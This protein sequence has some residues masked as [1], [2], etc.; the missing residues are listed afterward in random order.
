MKKTLVIAEKH[1]AALPMAK[2]LNCIIEKDGYM[3]GDEYII[4]WADGHL[5]GYQYPEEYNADY[6]EWKLEDLPLKFEPD[7]CLKVL[8]GKEKQFE[9]IKRLIQGE[10]TDKIINAGDAGRE[11]YLIQ[12]WI[13]KLAGNKKPVK[14]LW[15]S[16]L[17]EDALR[18]AFANLRDDSEFE[19][20]RKE[21]EARSEMDYILGMNYSRLLTLKCSNDITL[22]YGRCMT[23]LLNLIVERENEISEFE[24]RK[25]YSVE[26]EFEDGFKAVLIDTE[27]KEVVFERASD[28][29]GVI[30][31]IIQTEGALT[32]NVYE[33]TVKEKSESVAGLYSLPELQTVMGKKYKYSPAETLQIAQSLYEKQILTY[34]RTDSSYLPEDMEKSIYDNLSC[35]SFGKFKTALSR[36]ANEEMRANKKCFNDEKLTDHHA[37]I[38]DTNYDM[39]KIYGKLTEVEKNVFDEITYRFLSIFAK[40][41][42]TRSVSVTFLINGYLF[43]CTES[44]ELEPGYKLLRSVDTEKEAMIPFFQFKDVEEMR[45]RSAKIAEIKIKERVTEPPSRY[46]VGSIIELMQKH[47]IGTSATR[48]ATIEKLL[49]EKRPLLVLKK[50]KYYSS[51]F[52]RMY[53]TVV[54]EEL[55]NAELTN[56]MEWKLQQ[57]KEGVLEKEDVVNGIYEEFRENMENQNFKRMTF[58]RVERVRSPSRDNYKKRRRFRYE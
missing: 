36:C 32:G 24:P 58:S 48:A 19:D 35:C 21:A 22:P 54:P 2:V 34:P 14:V 13:Y 26:A 51:P 31:E 44:V 30:K 17:T 57:V 29:D 37:L 53:V 1:L 46:T 50:G 8:P 7:K 52:G 55:R 20:I 27:K 28:A 9:V 33:L 3:E 39:E 25:T 15:P 12:Y 11:G 45:G 10:E 38:P 6:K 41:R 40:E 47:N 5:I 49:D 42:I 23:T 56:D 4:T 16:S 43:R 18:K